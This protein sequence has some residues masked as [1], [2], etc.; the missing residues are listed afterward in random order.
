MAYLLGE[1]YKQRIDRA[2]SVVEGV[3]LQ[4]NG[5]RI[6]TRFE[7]LPQP[8]SPNP[9]ELAAY[10]RDLVWKKGSTVEVTL[11][12]QSGTAVGP[13]MEVLSDGS[14]IPRTVSVTNVSGDFFVPN[15]QGA[16]EDMGPTP[17]MTWCVVGKPRRG[18]Q[19]VAVEGP[20]VPVQMATISTQ[21]IGNEWAKGDARTVQITATGQT[22]EVYSVLDAHTKLDF[23]NGLVYTKSVDPND[24]TRT[25]NVVIGPPAI[26]LHEAR[27]SEGNLDEE[28]ARGQSKN[29]IVARQDGEE[30]EVSVE[31]KFFDNIKPGTASLAIGRF[32]TT[33]SVIASGDD[34]G[35]VTPG[36]LVTPIAPNEQW[37]AGS[38]RSIRITG[39]TTE[40]DVLNP[41]EELT[42]LEGHRGVIFA[43]SE[44]DPLGGDG[45]VNILISPAPKELFEARFSQ[46]N[47]EDEWARGQTKELIVPSGAGRPQD[48]LVPVTNKFFD[49]FKP[50]TASLAIGKIDGEFC[51]LTN[52]GRSGDVLL[53][54]RTDDSAWQQGSER[55]VVVHGETRTINA[56]NLA[57]DYES[58]DAKEQAQGPNLLVVR[59]G[60]LGAAGGAQWYVVAPPPKAFDTGTWD[61]G[62][63]AGTQK[64]FY[65]DSN[66]QSVQASNT[67]YNLPAG[68]SGAVA[69]VDG[70]W[71][72]VAVALETFTA[73]TVQQVQDRPYVESFYL[74]TVVT[75][76]DVAGQI[77]QSAASPV[78]IGLTA[79]TSQVSVLDAVSV[80]ATLNTNTCSIVTGVTP[81]RKNITL[82]TSVAVEH[83]F[84]VSKLYVEF[85]ATSYTAA[86]RAVQNTAMGK[87]VESTQTATMLRFPGAVE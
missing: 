4:G 16:T 29:L 52:S 26:P 81:T 37:E 82:V 5:T 24:P 41:F 79:N 75:G 21:Q 67:L 8:A 56:I 28:W 40:V 54:N 62:W 33:F 27:F 53:A 65:L 3:P 49:P 76:V 19:Y 25:A 66:G 12:T 38:L 44:K 42:P 59:G 64:Q 1:P 70:S 46:G 48:I 69:K 50:G 31:N 84:D 15:P 18:D 83:E 55:S 32:G 57:G 35:K 74:A 2:L 13:A 36:T 60:G 6:E 23:P 34:G 14:Q 17:T 72:L 78:T 77:K 22:V 63:P 10:P 87:F 11:Y 47:I 20:M 68:A 58:W 61:D 39:T 9:I 80:T 85:T 45:T 43:E 51:V 71:K 86:I 7:T 30:I 73:T